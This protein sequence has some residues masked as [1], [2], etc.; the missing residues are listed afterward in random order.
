MAMAAT[1]AYGAQQ[2]P[3]CYQSENGGITC[4]AGVDD[5]GVELLFGSKKICKINIPDKPNYGDHMA[6]TPT[7]SHNGPVRSAT[8]IQQCA[9]I[10]SK[11]VFQS[12]G[13]SYSR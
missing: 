9:D 7:N 8:C 13:I 11:T 5:H 2:S 12:R 6:C 4:D 3:V 10:C 1:F